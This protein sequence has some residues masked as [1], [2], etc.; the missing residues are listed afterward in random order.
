MIAIANNPEGSLTHRMTAGEQF[1]T[2]FSR[3]ITEEI[4]APSA[5]AEGLQ[6][7]E[8]CCPQALLLAQRGQSPRKRS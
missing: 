1:D 8:P 4:W 6:A 3:F 2:G 7:I 5:G